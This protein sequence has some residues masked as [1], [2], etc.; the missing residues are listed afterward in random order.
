MKVNKSASLTWAMVI[1]AAII[2]CSCGNR[3]TY[4]EYVKEIGRY[5]K[6]S[7]IEMDSLLIMEI[8]PNPL[9][10]TP[11][12]KD[13]IPQNLCLCIRN[14]AWDVISFVFIKGNDSIYIRK[15]REFAELFPP[16]ERDMNPKGPPSNPPSYGEYVSPVR[17]IISGNISYMRYSDDRYFHFSDSA[18]D[19]LP[20]NDSV[21][22]L[23][24]THYIERGNG[25]TFLIMKQSNVTSVDLGEQQI[26]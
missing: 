6:F 22:V 1:V 16:E 18:H 21:C 7:E 13:S 4:C 9:D 26:F 10:N 8:S 3:R 11:L 12:N 23:T 15:N 20:L 2:V 24:I 5:I 25:Y 19:Y 17:K 14:N